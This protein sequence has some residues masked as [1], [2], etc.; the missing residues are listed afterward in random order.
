MAAVPFALHFLESPVEA[1]HDSSLSQ[2]WGC[3]GLLGAEPWE[4]PG[5]H[6]GDRAWQ[7]PLAIFG[8]CLTPL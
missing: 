8:S 7:P 4:G 1:R 2:G 6:Q 3:V 5:S